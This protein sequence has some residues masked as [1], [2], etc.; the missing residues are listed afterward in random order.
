MVFQ[1]K[2]IDFYGQFEKWKEKESNADL[3][4]VYR[5]FLVDSDGKTKSIQ[6]FGGEDSTGTLYYGKSTD[7]A[8]RLG[9]LVNLLN[10]SG[11]KKGHVMCVRYRKMK[12]VQELAPV[13]NLRVEVIIDSNPR[14]KEIELLEKYKALFGEQPPLNYQ[15]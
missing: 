3:E 14:A 7:L 12:R 15:S 8:S 4:G 6:R 13:E 9:K 5:V 10:D 2:H 11:P 1:V